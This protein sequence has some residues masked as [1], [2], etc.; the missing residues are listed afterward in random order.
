MKHNAARS[1]SI[2]QLVE[3]ALECDPK[4]RAQF[5]EKACPNEPELRAEVESLLRFHQKADKLMERPAYE[6]SAAILPEEGAELAAGDIVDNYK[7]LSVLGEG[8]MGEVYLAEDLKTG[9]ARC[10]KGSQTRRRF[11]GHFASFAQRAKNS[12]GTESRKY[13]APLWD[14]QYAFWFALFCDGVCRG[15]AAR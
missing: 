12:R 9:A 1:D 8:G 11:P 7:V 13:R 14:G 2:A 15:R 6:M 10:T 5:L 3:A 4:E